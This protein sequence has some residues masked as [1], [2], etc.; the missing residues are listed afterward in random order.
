M[1]PERIDIVVKKLL[2]IADT[3]F[4]DYAG[5]HLD[6]VE[7]DKFNHCFIINDLKIH[8]SNITIELEEFEDA[9]KIITEFRRQKPEMVIENEDHNKFKH[10]TP[11]Y[12]IVAN[13]N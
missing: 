5:F 6:G 10:L 8:S 2:Q 9:V 1:T 4:S 13:I 12:P 3:K 11:F 7:D